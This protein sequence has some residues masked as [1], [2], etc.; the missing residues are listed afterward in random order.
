MLSY[1]QITTFVF[2]DRGVSGYIVH[3]LTLPYLLQ[4]LKNDILEKM[5]IRTS[6]VKSREKARTM[7]WT[8]TR[9]WR[10]DMMGY[11]RERVKSWKRKY[12]VNGSSF[13][14]GVGQT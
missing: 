1:S 13:A 2:C 11:P 14:S 6:S 5:G 8:I 10:E 4:V 3:E 9:C 7:G 12:E